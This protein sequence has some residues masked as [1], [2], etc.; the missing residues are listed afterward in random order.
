MKKRYLETKDWA[1]ISS[2]IGCSESKVY[3]LHK[4]ALSKIEDYLK[5]WSDLE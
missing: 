2:E 4:S 3:D 1:K 5:L